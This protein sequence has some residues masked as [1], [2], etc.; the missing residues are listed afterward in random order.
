MEHLAAQE[1]VLRGAHRVDESEVL[2]DGLDA[3]AESVAG[4]FQ[5]DLAAVEHDAPT[6]WREHAC[7][8][9]EQCR[10]ARSVVADEPECL[11]FEQL[12]RRVGDRHDRSEIAPDAVGNKDRRSALCGAEARRPWA[13]AIGCLSGKHARNSCPASACND[14]SFGPTARPPCRSQTATPSRA[15][16]SW[17]V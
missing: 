2:V 7:K 1:D 17:E 13:S 15:P 14:L 3:G 10:L 9:L 16:P 4:P 12:E 6:I 8:D 5:R 11:T